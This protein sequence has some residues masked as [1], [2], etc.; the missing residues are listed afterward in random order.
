MILVVNFGGPDVVVRV[1]GAF[2]GFV[3][4]SGV[5]VLRVTARM[6]CHQTLT[7]QKIGGSVKSG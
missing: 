2:L 1:V 3:A 5:V 6:P 7:S 4:R